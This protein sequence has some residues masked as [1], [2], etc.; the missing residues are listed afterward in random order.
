[1]EGFRLPNEE[2]KDDCNALVRGLISWIKTYE[3]NIIDCL[4]MDYRQNSL[5]KWDNGERVVIPCE[6]MIEEWENLRF[7]IS[8]ESE[9]KGPNA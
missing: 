9:V 4:G 3:Q 7:A 8:R 5:I 6:Q 1:M 2:E